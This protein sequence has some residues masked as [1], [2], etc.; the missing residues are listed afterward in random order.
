[1][2]PDP[3][4]KRVSIRNGNAFTRQI[5]HPTRTSVRVSTL[6]SRHPKPPVKLQR[7]TS[8]SLK[9]SSGN[10]KKPGRRYES[11][12][13]KGE[14]Q[15]LQLKRRRWDPVH[16]RYRNRRMSSHRHT[17]NKPTFSNSRNRC[18]PNLKFAIAL[19]SRSHRHCPVLLHSSNNNPRNASR[20]YQTTVNS[21]NSSIKARRAVLVALHSS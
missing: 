8:R 10:W 9:S 1:M 13:L 12:R 18:R 17:H 16:D 20:R 7:A 21:C 5:P 6:Q 15:S 4:A 3:F 14:P 11:L 19:S 2:A